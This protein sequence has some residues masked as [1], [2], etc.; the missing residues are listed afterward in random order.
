MPKLKNCK[1]ESRHLGLITAQ[2][3]GR[4]EDIVLELGKQA[5]ETIDIDEMLDLSKQS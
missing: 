2:E 1:L 5:L 4:F 3:V